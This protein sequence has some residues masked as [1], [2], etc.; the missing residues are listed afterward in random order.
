MSTA[1]DLTGMVPHALDSTVLLGAIVY[2][3]SAPSC[4]YIDVNDVVC[5]EVLHFGVTHESTF[6][7]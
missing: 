1:L 2:Y 6:L 4:I 5:F 7:S 3:S